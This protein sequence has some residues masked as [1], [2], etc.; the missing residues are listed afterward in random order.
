MLKLTLRDGIAFGIGSL[1]GLLI[2]EIAYS[3]KKKELREKTEEVVNLIDESRENLAALMK[4]RAAE[5]AKYE[6]VAAEYTMDDDEPEEVEQKTYDGPRPRIVKGDEVN[7]RTATTLY[8]YTVDDILTISAE[9]ENGQETE[10]PVR[11]PAE[12]EEMV[13]D[14]LT[15]FNFKN[16]DEEVIYVYCPV[17]NKYYQII[18]VRYS[19]EG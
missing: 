18:K 19:F 13:G 2:T 4:I 11:D 9:L 15:K 1:I 10:E 3:K 12:L 14:T 17:R 6:D 5:T 7:L 8:Y 16:S